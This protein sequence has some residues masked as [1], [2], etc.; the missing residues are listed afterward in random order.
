VLKSIFYFSK[1]MN[2]SKKM[3]IKYVPPILITALVLTVNCLLVEKHGSLAS[4]IKA[5]DVKD[6]I[7][8]PTFEI[9]LLSQTS[10]N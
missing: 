2:K 7:S 5:I 1:T 4:F 6:D 9:I 3:F 8:L 10:I